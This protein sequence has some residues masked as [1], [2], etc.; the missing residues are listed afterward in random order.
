MPAHSEAEGA[1]KRF[2]AA[3][4]EEEKKTED[5]LASLPL[6]ESPFAQDADFDQFE[7]VA[8]FWSKPKKNINTINKA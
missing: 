7:G 1:Y 6:I 3:E 2:K 4:P 5:L 8:T